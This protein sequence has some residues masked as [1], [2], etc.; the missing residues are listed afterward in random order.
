MRLTLVDL[1]CQTRLLQLLELVS[2]IARCCSDSVLLYYNILQHITT[3][4]EIVTSIG[5]K[6]SLCELHHTVTLDL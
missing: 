6:F 5:P 1:A 3:V 2:L 4:F